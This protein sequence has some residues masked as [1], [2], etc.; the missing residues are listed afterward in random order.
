[1][2]FN[3]KLNFNSFLN[4]A[5]IITAGLLLQSCSTSF[6][7]IDKPISFSNE[8]INLT[9][10]YQKNHY[11]IEKENISI[12]PKIIVLHWTAINS[13]KKTF[14][15]F[16]QEKLEGSRPDLTNAGQVNV[17]IQ[18]VV[19][20]NGDVYRLMPETEMARHVI[21]INY[22]SIGVENIGGENDV[23]DLTDDQIESNI[24]LIRYLVKKHPTIEYLIGHFEY[25]EFEG[26]P[27]WKEIDSTYRTEKFDPGNRFMNA[28]RTGVSDLHLKGVKVVRDENK[29]SKIKKAKAPK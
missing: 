17:S 4:A 24:E 27:L 26:H 3:W 25:R 28:V 15:T 10:E 2:N 20:K 11:G 16:N 7:I 6:K 13:L 29:K 23:D 19:D 1:M 9:E 5:I 14:D 18:F 12:I 8:R 22:C 21:G